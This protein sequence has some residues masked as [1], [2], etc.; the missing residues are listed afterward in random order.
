MDVRIYN[1][2]YFYIFAINFKHNSVGIIIDGI[3]VHV[4]SAAEKTILREMFMT[5]WPLPSYSP[6]VGLYIFCRAVNYA[7]F[8]QLSFN[9]ANGW[10]VIAF[11]LTYVI[12]RTA[13]FPPSFL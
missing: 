3:S 10:K 5:L 2:F 6:Y 13:T 11:R 7:H 12:C 9:F 4:Q 8:R 1:L